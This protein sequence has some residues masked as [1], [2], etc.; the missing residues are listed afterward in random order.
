MLKKAT[1]FQKILETLIIILGMRKETPKPPAEIGLKSID[2][3]PDQNQYTF[4]WEK[5]TQAAEY[6]FTLEV[7]KQILLTKVTD[8]NELKI[9]LPVGYGSKVKFKVQS[10]GK[11]GRESKTIADAFEFRETVAAVEVIYRRENENPDFSKIC[12]SES[13]YIKFDRVSWKATG[14][15]RFADYYFRKDDFCGC[16]AKSFEI[17]RLIN[18]IKTKNK[19][20]CAYDHDEYKQH[21]R[22][23]YAEY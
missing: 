20:V 6:K 12:N 17:K 21:G 23:T 3:R 1:L 8:N 22:Y 18:C 11:D 15:A 14:I 2:Y 16:I 5:V 13:Q 19:I 7:N 10:I 9:V 4:S